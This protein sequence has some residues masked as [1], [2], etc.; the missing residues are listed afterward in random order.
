MSKGVKV[1]LSPNYRRC[2]VKELNRV[3]DEFRIYGPEWNKEI[4]I[5]LIVDNLSRNET[6]DLIDRIEKKPIS[7]WND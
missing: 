7:E 4:I 5:D 3:L 1:R 2:V 6:I